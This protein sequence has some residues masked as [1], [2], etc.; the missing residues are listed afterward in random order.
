MPTK[1]GVNTKKKKARGNRCLKL[2]NIMALNKIET[3]SIY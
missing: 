2:F 3:I 1:D